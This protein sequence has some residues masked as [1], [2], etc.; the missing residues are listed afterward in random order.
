[1]I[2]YVS[3]AI[4][5]EEIP[6]EVCLTIQLSNCPF[7]CDGCH[8]PELQQDIGEDLEKDFPELLARYKD[9]ITCVCFMGDGPKGYY[10]H[11]RKIAELAHDAGLKT[12]QYS[13]YPDWESH[14]LNILTFN[15][16]VQSDFGIYDPEFVE[17][18]TSFDA[19]HKYDYVKIGNYRKDLGGLD[20][21]TTNQRMW[22]LNPETNGYEDITYRFWN[23]K[24][25][26]N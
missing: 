26:M 11:I 7:H 13:G 18:I 16:M 19:S 24:R 5:F 20:S 9:R 21:P 8:S 22:K 23:R 25:E 6:D 14:D 1:M 4:T 15:G 12:A 10:W 3:Y 2:K 17:L